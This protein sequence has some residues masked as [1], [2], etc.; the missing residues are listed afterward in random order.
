[1]IGLIGLKVLT[2]MDKERQILLHNLLTVF[3][4]STTSKQRF[5]PSQIFK[6]DGTGF[7][8]F[9]LERYSFQINVLNTK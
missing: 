7:P 5:S 8:V 4:I 6:T 2:K 3:F 1:M 9:Q